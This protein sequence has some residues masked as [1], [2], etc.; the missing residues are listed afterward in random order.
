MTHASSP[1]APPPADHLQKWPFC[2]KAALL[3]LRRNRQIVTQLG[4]SG[5]SGN[6]QERRAQCYLEL[7]DPQLGHGRFFRYI[8]RTVRTNGVSHAATAQFF[9]LC[10]CCG[11]GRIA[12]VLANVCEW[13]Q[14]NRERRSGSRLLRH[15]DSSRLSLVRT[16]RIGAGSHHEPLALAGI[17]TDSKWGSG[18]GGFA[19]QPDRHQQLRSA[20]RRL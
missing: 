9:V 6:F 17:G 18:I 4:H 15:L 19:R 13:R 10:D 20:C 5:I 12:R 1:P 8:G 2:E 14:S 7:S 11:V 16:A 3:F